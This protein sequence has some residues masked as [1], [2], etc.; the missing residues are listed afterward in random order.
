MFMFLSAQHVIAMEK[1]TANNQI[2]EVTMHFTDV[3]M[4]EKS[5]CRATRPVTR[6]VHATN[7]LVDSTLRLL[8]QGVSK[9]E[10]NQN[11]G[12]SFGFN[13]SEPLIKYYI[14]VTIKDGIAIVNFQKGAMVYLDGAL[15]EQESV[16]API[17]KT[18]LEFPSIVEVKYAID[19]KIVEEFDV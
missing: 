11:L 16:K 8:F 15:C 5:D 12:D 6:K 18:L 9:D 1:P 10:K 4:L 19:G 3:I 13:S 2:F 17:E 7:N 14:G